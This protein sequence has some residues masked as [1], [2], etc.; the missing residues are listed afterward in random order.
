[1]RL[2]SDLGL[3]SACDLLVGPNVAAELD[4]LHAISAIGTLRLLGLKMSDPPG[5]LENEF[6]RWGSFPDPPRS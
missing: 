4:G 6:A 5:H 3:V 1:M 2:C